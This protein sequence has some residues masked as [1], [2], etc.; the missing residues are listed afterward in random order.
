[1]L[2]LTQCFEGSLGDAQYWKTAATTMV[3]DYSS[4]EQDVKVEPIRMLG[5]G[6]YFE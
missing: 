5:L 1:M 2:Y 3:I 4:L 6:L